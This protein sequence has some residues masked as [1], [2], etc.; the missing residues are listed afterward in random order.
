MGRR[1][2]RSY[3]VEQSGS[4]HDYPRRSPSMRPRG[5]VERDMH[6]FGLR[7]S[8]GRRLSKGSIPH[9]PSFGRRPMRGT[10]YVSSMASMRSPPGMRCPPSLPENSCGLS[11]K[12]RLPPYD[13][14][15]C[16]SLE[17]DEEDELAAIER[18]RRIRRIVKYSIYAVLGL[19]LVLTCSLLAYFLSPRT[20]VVALHAVNSPD[21]VSNSK[22]KLQG[23]KLQFHVDLIYRVQ[24]DN[25][26]DMS[27]GDIST[28][29]FWPDTN[30]AL[31]G[32]RLSDIRI[33]A[34]RT[35][36]L[37]MPIAMR[38]DVKRGPPPVLLGMV[39]SCGLHD[40]GIGEMNLEAEVQ[41]DV[42]TKMKQTAIQSGRQSISVKCPVRHMA[43]LQ[44]DD[45]TSGNLGDIVRM[46]NA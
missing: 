23:T 27:V 3:R 38:Y 22:F 5:S 37:T 18:T 32:G 45:G 25:F 1:H 7:S 46:L 20:P 41:A 42:R 44:V 13:T 9:A 14:T 6:R 34:R 11:E 43:M 16:E 36:Q 21:S 19:L 2:G 39:E 24:N 40:S 31:G 30:F 28:A 29:V 33:P 12:H 4:H 35:V 8:L 26:F 10:S 17:E 15:Y